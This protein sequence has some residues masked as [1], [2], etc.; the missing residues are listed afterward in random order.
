MNLTQS[1]FPSGIDIGNTGIS[2]KSE[3]YLA[4]SYPQS[5]D[6]SNLHCIPSQDMIASVEVF[7]DSWMVQE[8]R[9]FATKK[10]DFGCRSPPERTSPGW[11]RWRDVV[12]FFSKRR[13]EE[14]VHLHCPPSLPGVVYMVHYFRLFGNK[15][16]H[17]T[18]ISGKRNRMKIRRATRWMCQDNET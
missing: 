1:I 6:D 16:C 10:N 17:S 8:G 12:I 9:I 7:K 4:H 13:T 5:E 15:T 2:E 18:P 14:R 11:K 3:W